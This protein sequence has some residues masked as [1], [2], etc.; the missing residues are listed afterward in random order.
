MRSR[1]QTFAAFANS[2]L[3]IE[4]DIL[5]AVQRF[6]DAERSRIL[7]TI[8]TNCSRIDGFLSYDEEIDKRKYSHLKTWIEERLEAFDVDK[9]F[10]WLSTVELSV[11]SD[12]IHSDD[13]KRLLRMFQSADATSYRLS[14]TV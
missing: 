3:P 13:E 14:E 10:A 7:D 9:E 11:H 4:L 5:R 12:S 1:L 8:S 2:L 6:E